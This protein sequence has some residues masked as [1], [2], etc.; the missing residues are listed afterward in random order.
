M[1][2]PFLGDVSRRLHQTCSPDDAIEPGNVCAGYQ[3][4]PLPYQ[5]FAGLLAKWQANDPALLTF[6]PADTIITTVLHKPHVLPVSFAYTDGFSRALFSHIL[7][8]A[9]PVIKEA[10]HSGQT[11]VVAKDSEILYELQW[12]LLKRISDV[13]ALER[14]D[15][16]DNFMVYKLAEKRPFQRGR[17]LSCPTDRS[18]HAMVFE[19]ASPRAPAARRV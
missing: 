12:A 1:K 19:P 6:H 3:Q 5:E 2:R 15:E 14:V 9:E 11:L 7:S 8:R 4:L 18:R 13:W 17:A 16:T 10:L